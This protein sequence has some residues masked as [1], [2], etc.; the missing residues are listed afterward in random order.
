M[1]E[2]TLR[3]GATDDAARTVKVLVG[4]RY[5]GHGYGPGTVTSFPGRVARSLI[6]HGRVVEAERP[7]PLRAP[8]PPKPVVAAPEPVRPV[9][10]IPLVEIRRR[11]TSRW[12]E[13]VA[14]GVVVA[15]KN[16]LKAAE[17][18]R[19]ALLAGG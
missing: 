13:I 15:K 14:D 16:G 8:A 4:F 11:G 10:H 1:N 19:D 12:Y 5:G 2:M 6:L 18:A 9:P 3:G 17:A 7:A